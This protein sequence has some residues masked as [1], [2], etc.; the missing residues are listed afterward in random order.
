MNASSIYADLKKFA[1]KIEAKK[2]S[3]MVELDKEMAN[4]L[5]PEPVI[6]TIKID[7]STKVRDALTRN[8]TRVKTPRSTVKVSESKITPAVATP[9]ITIDIIAAMIKQPLTPIKDANGF[10]HDE[11]T[12]AARCPRGHIHKYFLKDIIADSGANTRCHTCSS[13]NKFM[14][15][16]R[17][18]MENTLGVPFILAE[19]RLSG[20][21]N[22]IEYSNPMLKITIVCGRTPGVNNVIWANDY[23]VV[24][25]HP[26][27]SLRKIKDSLHKLL[28]GQDRLPADV[29]EKINSLEAAPAGRDRGDK[30]SM[31]RFNKGALPYTNELARVQIASMHVNPIIAQ[32]QMN[33]IDD[34]K[35]CLENC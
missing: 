26:T 10:V 17:E 24:K 3:A 27:T 28:S 6:K 2:V 30:S 29:L 16:T 18:L 25:L 32:M 8:T 1:G 4:E 22:A 15:M 33:I 31:K 23:L 19:K 20:D 9:E 7:N 5:E 11:S 12:I 13:G 35:L 34:P 21:I 14:I